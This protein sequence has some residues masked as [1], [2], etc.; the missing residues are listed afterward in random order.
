[1]KRRFRKLV[2]MAIDLSRSMGGESSLGSLLKMWMDSLEM[3]QV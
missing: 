3:D 2:S 1:M